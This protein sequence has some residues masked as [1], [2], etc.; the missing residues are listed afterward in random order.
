MKEQI[1]LIFIITVCV[2][3]LIFI[4]YTSN[5]E[6]EPDLVHLIAEALGT[7]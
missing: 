3:L 5:Q 6:E 7:P 2:I 1:Y 4:G